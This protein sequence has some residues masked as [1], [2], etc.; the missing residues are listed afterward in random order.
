MSLPS[1]HPLQRYSV[2]GYQE[3]A[4]DEGV[5]WSCNLLRH[6]QSF[7]LVSNEGRGGV[8]DYAFTDSARGEEFLAAAA[9]L[10]PDDAHPADTLVARVITIR[11]F[12]ALDQIAYCL[13]DDR[14]DDLG[15]HRLAEPGSSFEQVRAELATRFA[16]R[17]PRIWDRSRSEMVPVDPRP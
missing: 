4:S 6:G 2:N 17:H 10:F 16:G 13:D 12:N 1:S 3:A 8:N 15:E 14:F 9:G 7:G 5:A 11:Q